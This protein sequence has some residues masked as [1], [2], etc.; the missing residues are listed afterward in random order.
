MGGHKSFEWICAHFIPEDGSSKFLR[1][2]GTEEES[3]RFVTH[4]GCCQPTRSERVGAFKHLPSRCSAM[5]QCRWSSGAGQVVLLALPAVK[6]KTE[7]DRQTELTPR[8]SVPP[9]PRFDL[10]IN[11]S[12]LCRA[13]RSV[14]PSPIAVSVAQ[15]SRCVRATCEFCLPTADEV[16]LRALVVWSLSGMTL[17]GE[18]R[19]TEKNLFQCYSVRHWYG[20]PHWGPATEK[21]NDLFMNPL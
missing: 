13:A 9:S 8:L 19:S 21:S 11:L 1:K 15:T 10:A 7:I 16:R 5:R 18:N 4:A 6:V 2:V 17:A 3:V 14:R 20:L 12:S